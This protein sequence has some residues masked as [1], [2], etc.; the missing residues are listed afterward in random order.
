MRLRFF[1]RSEV[2]FLVRCCH[3]IRVDQRAHQALRQIG[4]LLMRCGGSIHGG[5]A[6]INPLGAR[7]FISLFM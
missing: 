5:S 7:I 2:S 6:L 4:N 1:N 3:V